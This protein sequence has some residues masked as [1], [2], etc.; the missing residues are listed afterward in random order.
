M[1]PQGTIFN[2]DHIN[3]LIDRINA[4]QQCDELQALVGEVFASMQAQLDAIGDQLAMLQ[5]L[6]DLLAVPTSLN[7]IISWLRN[8]ITAFLGPYVAAYA[9]YAAQLTAVVAAIAQLEAA[10]EA[11]ARRLTS[12]SI[13]V[14]SLNKPPLPQLPPPESL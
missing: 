14:P 7:A 2:T 5:P 12:C 9:K 6:L 4:T 1:Q 10:I 11:A 13:S 3:A 8:F